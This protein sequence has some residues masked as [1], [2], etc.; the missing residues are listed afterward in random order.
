MYGNLDQYERRL[1]EFEKERLAHRV[2]LATHPLPK[3]ARRMQARLG[4]WLVVWGLALQAQAEPTFGTM[5]A[6]QPE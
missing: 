5:T 4:Q 3:L 2:W 1:R 6:V